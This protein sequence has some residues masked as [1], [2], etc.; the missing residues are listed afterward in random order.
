MRIESPPWLDLPG[1]ALRQ[2]ERADR[3]AW[4]DY[5]SRPEVH[6]RTSW[7]L[8]RPEDLDPLFDAFESTLAGSPC[9]LAV[10]DTNH[11]R[12]AGT[13]G[14]HTLSEVH[15]NGEIAYDLAPDYWGRGLATRLCATV[16]RWSF[17]RLGLIRVQGTVLVGN[18]PSDRVLLKCG[19]QREGLLRS[20]RLVRGTP[21]DFT[22]YARLATDPVP[23]T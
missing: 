21:G 9:R 17:E 2:I 3:Q 13:I 15:R 6:A 8:R 23:A 16:T 20:F 19:F 5:L 12:L 10:V 14:F 11:D 4:Y 18:A 22:L 7:N 1:F